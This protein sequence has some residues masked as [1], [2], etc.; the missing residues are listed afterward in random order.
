VAFHHRGSD[1]KWIGRLKKFR[2]T[3][4]EAIWTLSIRHPGR[5]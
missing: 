1:K 4:C 3:E 5:E 2:Q